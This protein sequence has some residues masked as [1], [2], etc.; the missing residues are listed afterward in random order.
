M[1]EK[2]HIDRLFQEKFKDFETQPPASVWEGIRSELAT[3]AKKDRK[4]IPLWW[5]VAGIAAML[6]LLFTAIT[7]WGPESSADQLVDSD[8]DQIENTTDTKDEFVNSDAENSNINKD[9]VANQDATT[10]SSDSSDQNNS[11]ALTVDAQKE[12]SEGVANSSQESVQNKKT[13]YIV[14]KNVVNDMIKTNSDELIKDATNRNDAV[15]TS[16][17]ESNSKDN[18]TVDSEQNTDSQDVLINKEA[19]T[20]AFENQT[21]DAV[22]V[23]NNDSNNELNKDAAQD[24]N[25]EADS[26]DV[27]KIDINEYIAN[28]EQEE[29]IAQEEADLKEQEFD[30]KRWSV[31]PQVAPVFYGSLSEGSSISEEFADNA[32][33]SDANLSYGVQV[34]YN[35]NDRFS[36]RSGVNKVNLSYNTNDIE[37][38]VTP[39]DVSLSGTKFVNGNIAYTVGDKGTLENRLAAAVPTT[40]DAAPVTIDAFQGQL[41]QRLEYWEVP[42]EMSYALVNKRFR[43]NLLG[44]FSSLIL[45]DNQVIAKSGAREASLG[46]SENLNSF[47]FT[48]NIGLGL[49]YNIT[50]QFRISME[51]MFK[52]QLNPY[53]DASVD[54]KPYYMGV[55]TGLSFRF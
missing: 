31:A 37:F 12:L 19:V 25:K 17:Q 30:G 33:S 49:N 51:P 22:G 50:D 27:G 9:A 13:N 35:V 32:K 24:N 39:G 4:V 38:A 10:E 47:S 18:T 46:S 5:R 11:D 16:D 21:T 2:K 1:S 41:N 28:K 45:Q 34:S 29:A 7:F 3:P 42:V 20:D 43:L 15:V 14:N 55:Y 40:E 8:A 53:S 52:Y 6:A 48:T 54:F 36:I 23:T 44:G 26:E